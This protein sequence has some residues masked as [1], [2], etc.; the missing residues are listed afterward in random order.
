MCTDIA[1]ISGQLNFLDIQ[2]FFAL[3]AERQNKITTVAVVDLA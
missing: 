3:G 2:D 1:G